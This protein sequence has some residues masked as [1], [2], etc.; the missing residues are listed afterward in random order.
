MVI[1]FYD[2]AGLELEAMEGRYMKLVNPMVPPSWGL[3]GP[4]WHGSPIKFQGNSCIF[5]VHTAH[6]LDFFKYDFSF[7]IITIKIY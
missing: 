4:C 3:I 2:L 7:N 6:G 1:F 5:L